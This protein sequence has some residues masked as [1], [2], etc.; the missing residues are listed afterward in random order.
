MLTFGSPAFLWGLLALAAPV[1]VHLI[2]RERAVVK[3]FPSTRFIDP[4][5]LPQQGRRRL[6]DYLLLAL[7]M[8]V[9]AA[10]ILALA[11]PRWVPRDEQ[12][13]VATDAPIAIFVVDSSASMGQRGA[14]NRVRTA[15]DQYLEGLPGNARVGLVAYDDEIRASMAPTGD[16]QR[17]WQAL[18]EAEFTYDRAGRPAVGLAEAARLL[19]GRAG[20]VIVFSDFQASDWQGVQSPRLPAGSELELASVRTEPD[21]NVGIQTATVF[22]A[23]DGSLR[24]YARLRN[25]WSAP[26]P[27]TLSLADSPVSVDAELPAN[28]S[29]LVVL[30]APGDWVPEGGAPARLDL[31]VRSEESWPDENLYRGDDQYH[32]W[33]GGSPGF[34]I[35]AMI[36]AEEEP[37]KLREASFVARALEV[38]DE[39]AT[40]RFEFAPIEGGATDWANAVD[41]LYLPGTGAYFSEEIWARVRDFVEAGGV[42]LVTP[43]RAA[44]RLFRGM[45]ESGLSQT[46]YVGKPRRAHDRSDVY[47]IGE[48]PSSGALA[49]VFDDEAREDL[50]LA[51]IYEYWR[52]NPGPEAEV[53]LETETGDPLLV[54]ERLGDGAV[55]I[56]ALDFDP[57]ATDLPLRN[58]FV[59]VLWELLGESVS[60]E[61]QAPEIGV[62]E[63]VPAAMASDAQT[64]EY[65]TSEPGVI[66]VDGA[67]LRINV[68]RSESV[69]QGAVLAD[70]RGQI[71]AAT[72]GAAPRDGSGAGQPGSPLWPWLGALALLACI[73]EFVLAQRAET[74][75]LAPA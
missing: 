49:S 28:S 74:P 57:S 24:V 34:V 17:V 67:P 32:F 5:R 26:V 72:A 2:N 58:S 23:R 59:P 55:I 47:R 75:T 73:F 42:L 8:L 15:I 25:D 31:A 22:P 52:V 64:G 60:R 10:V 40:R 50:Y 33:L 62:G 20:E 71:L 45:R 46:A 35:G 65:D 18:E 16:R 27:V 48:L 13:A 29:E 53:V 43:S 4:S 44:P 63:P 3:R 37:E 51:D 21:R 69:A 12:T 61:D 70:L 54:R 39:S 6:R 9:Y 56:S 11:N 7:R 66:L 38:G 1:I 68:D 41:A 30:S 19:E 36:P 14:F